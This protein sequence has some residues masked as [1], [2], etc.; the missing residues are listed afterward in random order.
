MPRTWIWT[1]IRTWTGSVA[2]VR[3]RRVSRSDSSDVI[4]A[5]DIRIAEPT[6]GSCR[7][8]HAG[9][10]LVED[11]ATAGQRRGGCGSGRSP[12]SVD[13]YGH[14]SEFE[15]GRSYDVVTGDTLVRTGRQGGHPDLLGLAR[16]VAVQAVRHHRQ[17]R[18]FQLF[19][20]T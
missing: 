14:G 17:V 11:H 3:E 10:R 16:T 2:G 19:T 20:H 8:L 15:R 13:R 12:A 4:R 18:G 7:V 6:A 5:I 9:T 1:R